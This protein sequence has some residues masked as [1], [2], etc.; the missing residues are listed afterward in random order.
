MRP[1]PLL[2]ALLWFPLAARGA[3]ATGPADPAAPRP[4][5]E[6][7]G[8][9]E[10]AL[11]RVDETLLDV[12]FEHRLGFD[13][14]RR[15]NP[16]VDPW[17]PLPGIVVRLPTRWVPPLAPRQGLLI[18]VPEMRLFDYTV[19]PVE[20]FSVAVGDRT[21]PTLLGEFRV[22]AKRED[23]AWNVPDS[24]REEKPEL[25]AVVPPGPSNPLGDRWM[26]IGRTSYGIHGTNIRWS[27]GREATHG[28]VRLYEDEMRRLYA[29]T[30]SGTPIRIV[31]Q[32]WKWGRD[33]DAVVLEAHPDLYGLFEDP[34]AEALRLADE[35]GVGG[36]VDLQRVRR[37]L[38]E[39]S[40][41][42][43]P[44]G[45]MPPPPPAAPTSTPTS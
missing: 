41:V 16:E 14:V 29:R 8:Q 39:A 43:E 3:P 33:G 44:V 22:G 11:I 15:A 5:P 32:P 31:Y 13:A 23:P 21:D 28:C 36:V 42:P 9:V 12:A 27:I 24:I 6:V 26:T 35:F 2:L 7:V 18:N 30:P 34:M 45:R 10:R 20:L 19:D 25:P 37:V 4:L 38:E 40:G 1:I 17:I